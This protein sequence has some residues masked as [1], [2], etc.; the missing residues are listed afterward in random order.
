MERNELYQIIIAK[1]E[2]EKKMRVGRREEKISVKEITDIQVKN[3]IM[4]M[5]Y[6]ILMLLLF[7]SSSC[8]KTLVPSIVAEMNR[9]DYDNAAFNYLYVDAIKNKLMGNEGEA[10]KNFL[11]MAMENLMMCTLH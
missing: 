3:R 5:K 6:I 4:R 1:H 11:S 8:N 10:L 9:K 2:K 7:F